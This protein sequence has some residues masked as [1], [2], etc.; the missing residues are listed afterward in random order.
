MALRSWCNYSADFSVYLTDVR[1]VF[2]QASED[3]YR[4]KLMELA[5]KWSAPF[6]EYYMDYIEPD[7]ALVARWGIEPLGIYNPYSDVTNNQAEGLNYVLKQLQQWREAPIDCMVL[8]LHHLHSYYLI[9]IARGQNGMGNYHLHPQFVDIID[10]VPFPSSPIYSP[11]EIVSRIRGQLTKSTPYT[12]GSSIPSIETGTTTNMEKPQLSSQ[13]GGQLSQRDRA[14]RVIA[15]NRISMDSKLH[16]FTVLGSERPHVVTLFP[17]ETCSC[18]STS[19]CYHILAAK[20]SIGF[21]YYQQSPKQKLNLTQLRRN[22]RS[23]GKKR[24][25]RKRP[26]PGDC[27]IFPAPDSKK[28][29]ADHSHQHD[30]TAGWLQSLMHVN[31]Y[32]S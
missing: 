15:D 28:S 32:C 1:N 4:K 12:E 10:T 9:E 23:T 21:D 29:T 16:T 17:K 22:A 31:Y 2:H 8:A 25:G 3:D 11:E 5:E 26:R 30:T 24:S 13:S 27:D 20:M 18:P 14:M 19:S 6:Y 7:I